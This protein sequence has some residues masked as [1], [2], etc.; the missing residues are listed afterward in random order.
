MSFK[1]THSCL[2]SILVAVDLGVTGAGVIFRDEDMPCLNDGPA[3][4][5][6]INAP[7]FAEF[8][9]KSHANAAVIEAVGPRPGEGAVGAFS[10]G[11]AKGLVEGTLA[12]AGIPITWIT[13][14]TW[15]RIV[16]ISA[17]RDGAKDAARSEAI[18]RWPDKAS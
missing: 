6:T 2:S 3:G 16:G 1:I 15:K 13:P 11:R 17:G 7:L 9:F 8:V 14:P 5:R 4:R 12:A 18:R 10:F